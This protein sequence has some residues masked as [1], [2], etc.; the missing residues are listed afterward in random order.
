MPSIPRQTLKHTSDE[1][2][3]QWEQR[4]N[5]RVARV[6]SPQMMQMPH[7]ETTPKCVVCGKEHAGTW[8]PLYLL[9]RGQYQFNEAMGVEMFV[10]D[11]NLK[12]EFGLLD[13]GLKVCFVDANPRTRKALVVHDDCW[14]SL[15][16]KLAILAN[17]EMYPEDIDHDPLA[18][19]HERYS[20]KK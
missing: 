15:E 18:E 14:D 8:T 5:E 12:I 2:Q 20:N 17:Y 16:Q 10:F 11:P 4:L 13:N 7:D 9:L 3:A 19:R 6:I 1:T